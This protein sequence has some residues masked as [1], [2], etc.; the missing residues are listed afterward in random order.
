MTIKNL[1]SL[2]NDLRKIEQLVIQIE[3]LLWF[4]LANIEICFKEYILRLLDSTIDA[5]LSRKG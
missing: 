2:S 1:N 4:V 3:I 5:R